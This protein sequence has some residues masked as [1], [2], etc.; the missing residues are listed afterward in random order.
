MVKQKHSTTPK[1]TH[2]RIDRALLKTAIFQLIDA[3]KFQM[4]R[5]GCVGRLLIT[6][7]ALIAAEKADARAVVE[8]GTVGTEAE[9]AA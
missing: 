4:D 8:S 1:P 7:N 9:V 6:A 3:A 2:V 5:T